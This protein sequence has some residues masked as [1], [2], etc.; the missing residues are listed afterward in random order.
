MKTLRHMLLACLALVMG[1]AMAQVKYD[2]ASLYRLSP[3]NV[4]G[5]SP[6][7]AR[8]IT[9]LPSGNGLRAGTAPLDATTPGQYFTLT[10][11]S[12]AWRIICPFTDCA[13]RIDGTRIAMGENNGSDEAQL[14]RIETVKST[15]HVMIIPANS[16][17]RAL[18]CA[19]DGSLVL[20]SRKSAGKSAHFAI[21]KTDGEGLESHL[22]ADFARKN[23]VATGHGDKW[24]DQTIFGEHKEPGIATYMPYASLEAMTADA[25]YYRTPWTEPVNDRY[26]SLNGMWRFNLVSEPDQRPRNFFAEDYDTSAWDSIPVPSNWEMQ[27]YDHPIYCNVEYPHGNTPPFITARPGFNDGGKN[28]GINPVGSYLRHFTLPR[29]WETRRTFVHFGGI[30]SAAYLWVNGKYVGYTQG[31][32][33]VAEF[34]LTQYLKTGDNTIAVQ[35]F[36]WSDGSYLEC[37]DMFRMS[38]IYR[39]VY[40]YSTPLVAIRDHVIETRLVDGGKSAEVSVTLTTDNRNRLDFTKVI[41]VSLTDPEGKIVAQGGYTQHDVKALGAKGTS[42]DTL[43]G[44]VVLNVSEPLLWTA[45][46]PWLY[47]LNVVQRNAE[48]GQD[49]L[50]FSTKC[51]IREVKIQGS[52]LLINGKPVLLKGVN[53]H[54]TSPTNGRAVTTDE[55]LRDV[56]LMKQNNINTVRTSHYPNAARMYAMLDYY[57]IY[58]CDEADLEDHA[59]Q[60]I[61]DDAT[62]IPAFVDRI[63]RLVTRDR[64]HP[65]VIIWSLGNEAGNGANFGPCYDEAHRLDS[66]RPVHYEGTRAAGNYGGGRFS[67]FYSKMYPGLDWMREHS[68]G[69]DKPMFVC[70]YAHAMGNAIGNLREYWDIIEASEDIIGGCIWDWVDQAI[71]APAGYSLVPT[72][73]EFKTAMWGKEGGAARPASAVD[74]ETSADSR[75]VSADNS[76]TPAVE[77]RLTTGYDYPGPHQGNFCSNGILPP[78][79]KASAK[80]AEV[81]AAYQY[82]KFGLGTVDLKR[83]TAEVTIS[84]A[85]TFR[86]LDGMDLVADFMV[87]GRVASS[88]ALPLDGVDAGEMATFA[89]KLPKSALKSAIKSGLETH[90]N[91]YVAYRDEQTFAPAGHTVAQMQY[92]ITERAALAEIGTAAKALARAAKISRPA[93][94]GQADGAGCLT[95]FNDRVQLRFDAETGA[96][97]TLAFDGKEVLTDGLPMQFSNHRWI[98]NDRFDNT[99]DGLS[100]RGILTTETTPGGNLLIHTEREGKLC[101]TVVDYEVSPIGIVDVTATFAPHTEDLRRAG[102]VCAL[103]PSLSEVTYY[104][105]GPYENYNDRR[106]GC[107]IGRYESR[108]GEMGEQYVKPQTM[109]DRTAM[110][111][112]TFAD[113]EG[114]GVRIETAD[115][116]SFSA[117]PYTDEDLMRAQHTWQLRPRP[118]TVLHLDAAARGVGNASCGQ[119]VDTLPEYRVAGEPTA[120]KLRFSPLK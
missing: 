85:Y 37:Q 101:S 51:G 90:L 97:I 41:A 94:L 29:G 4:G 80:L 83:A 82:I 19:A 49:E 107:M 78:S 86:S 6:A 9:H 88:I 70:E 39:D 95:F 65:C 89:L 113:A 79:R 108:V 47:T 61:S 56:L 2:A 93:P 18:S 111:E 109:G 77:P 17:D 84:N 35:V 60:S 24:E 11:L 16:P 100:D 15:P 43:T 104:A 75:P 8:Y 33:N 22:L 7:T 120:Y 73:T 5:K 12:G 117:N 66:T 96:L 52:K 115:N 116:V 23:V 31:A 106:D 69:L 119:D 64:N 59:N 103:N 112:V 71:Y 91:L 76:A 32:N 92:T 10:S 27:G 53:R 57:G 45:E 118:Y 3:V 62:W 20:V 54:D 14:W 42:H 87:D 26:L 74:S 36:R 1:T 40:L 28:Y 48:T 58:A 67:D 25:D 99:D 114:W 30:Y 38:G 50:A 13:L 46:T 34:D 63:N 98:E 72:E 44:N 55:M 81:K 102:M 110:R 105:F 21:T 68:T